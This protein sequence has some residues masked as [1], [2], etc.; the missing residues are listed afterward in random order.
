MTSQK[1]SEFFDSQPDLVDR[2]MK[3][4]MFGMQVGC[5]PWPFP[6]E[7]KIE[8]SNV[9][10][11][12]IYDIIV[13]S[14]I[15]RSSISYTTPE[16]AIEFNKRAS[17]RTGWFAISYNNPGENF[18]ITVDDK[19]FQIRSSN[20]RLES[21]VKLADMIFSK[22]TEAWCSE[23][24]AKPV[25]LQDRAFNV[26]YTFKTN[27]RLEKHKVQETKVK[28]YDLL[29]EMLSLD[30]KASTNG[31][32]SASEALLSV[33][34]DNV[35]RMDFKQH[36]TKEID[37]Q[38]YNTGIILDGPF[39][40]NNST[41]DITNFLRT[42]EEFGFNLNAGLR[43]DTALISFYRDIVIKRFLANL[44]CSTEYTYQ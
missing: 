16:E 26:D 11:R 3:I 23:P 20:L 8:Y 34:F 36:A 25:L 1:L 22:V 31:V 29:T 2:S 5:A 17:G 38:N 39:N 35:V 41:L 30:R 4:D 13:K 42:E 6:D 9:F 14:G 32:K 37:G 15:P 19:V 24:L 43:W 12:A 40:E 7:L 44:L 10:Y 28:N 18:S 33:G 27:L 21:L